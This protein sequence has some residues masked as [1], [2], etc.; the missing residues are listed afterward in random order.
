MFEVIQKDEA[1]ASDRRVYFSLVDATDGITPEDITVTGIKARISKNGGAYAATTADITKI[2]DSNN[3]PDYYIELTAAEVDTLGQIR[4]YVD[5]T[6]CAKAP[7]QVNIVN[8]DPTA[9]GPTVADIADGVL[10]EALAGHTTAGT[11][12]KALIDLLAGVIVSSIANNVITAAS[13][14][15]AAITSA[16]FAAGAI[17][18]SAIAADAIGA[19]ELAA[20]AVTEITTSV[21][22]RAFSAAYGSHTF[23][24]LIKLMSSVLLGKVSGLDTGTIV[25]RNLADNANTVNATGDVSGNRTA[26]T[27]TP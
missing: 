12:G 11:S 16:K 24:E 23:D 10:D 18:A 9:A 4:G 17:D 1:T 7:F 27:R 5:A 19:S 21:F 13:I 6:G 8:Y 25:F 2:S 22:A 26:V 20:D 3:K 14:N 15:A